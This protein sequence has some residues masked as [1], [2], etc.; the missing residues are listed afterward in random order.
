MKTTRFAILLG[1]LVALSACGHNPAP[2]EYGLEDT[3]QTA[4]LQDCLYGTSWGTGY[5]GEAIPLHH[6]LQSGASVLRSF[7]D[8]S[9]HTARVDLFLYPTGYYEALYR[10]YREWM[11][12]G[13]SQSPWRTHLRWLRG[14]WTLSGDA[15]LKLS[16][17][18]E[19]VPVTLANG[20]LGGRI[21]LPK[22]L[23]TLG[24][25][26]VSVDVSYVATPYDPRL[27]P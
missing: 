17:L 6:F 23:N 18:G 7:P 26:G 14:N 21:T 3:Q 4:R 22:A 10:E 11:V 27:N 2:S 25:E 9:V 1:A 16:E 8:G 24:L 20:V 12:D 19:V 5:W 15:G 13:T